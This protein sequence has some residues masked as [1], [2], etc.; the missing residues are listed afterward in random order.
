MWRWCQIHE[1]GRLNQH[2]RSR[3]GPM[4]LQVMRCLSCY[5]DEVALAGAELFTDPGSSGDDK[6]HVA[7]YC[8]TCGEVVPR[9]NQRRLD[10]PKREN[11]SRQC[12]GCDPTP[13]KRPIG[14]QGGEPDQ[15]LG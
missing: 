15:V 13:P 6:D 8:D 5:R 3:A 12:R 4:L 1:L 7:R 11:E 9:A 10:E 2:R 14:P